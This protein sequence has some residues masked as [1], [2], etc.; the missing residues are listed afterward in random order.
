MPEQIGPD[1][2]VTLPHYISEA[3]HRVVEVFWTCKIDTLFFQF[4]KF[5]EQLIHTSESIQFCHL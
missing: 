3:F 2:T 1:N 5:S 4:L